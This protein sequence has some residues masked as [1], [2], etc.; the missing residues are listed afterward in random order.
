MGWYTLQE[1][2]MA[3]LQSRGDGNPYPPGTKLYDNAVKLSAV[4]AEMKKGLPRAEANAK[5]DI[6]TYEEPKGTVAKV[7]GGAVSGF[8]AGG[9]VGAVI[10]AVGG[11]IAQ[12]AAVK[13]AMDTSAKNAKEVTNTVTQVIAAQEAVKKQEAA[14]AAA[15]ALQPLQAS[16]GS[17]ALFQNPWI[18][19]G[20]L[21]VAGLIT[22]FVVKK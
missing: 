14:K 22:F 7:V 18:V 21:I 2:Q 10:G 8:L 15:A 12:N 20:I 3:E 17:L 4:V 13:A 19:G 1:Y 5:W 11:G 6:V 16:A 9:P